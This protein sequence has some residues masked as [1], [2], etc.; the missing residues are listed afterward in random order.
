MPFPDTVLFYVQDVSRSQ[1]FYTPLLGAEPVHASADFVLYI[2]DKGL[3][4][5]LWRLGD[6]KPAASVTGG[7]GEI[8][9]TAKSRDEV[10]GLYTTWSKN[11]V[12][13]LQKP[14]DMQFIGY[15]FVAV[16]PDG[17]R[18]RVLFDA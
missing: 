6:A 10:D 17:H 14:V 5:A 1:A 13:F 11:E 15:S 2:G 18:I 3:K 12:E 16:D 9:F 4:F 7:G 8:N